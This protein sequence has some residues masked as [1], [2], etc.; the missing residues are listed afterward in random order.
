MT[1][2]ITRIV[3]RHGRQKRPESDIVIEVGQRLPPFY[4][5]GQPRDARV[6]SIVDGSPMLCTLTT[7]HDIMVPSS[8]VREITRA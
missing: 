5:A 1:D 2:T 3:I 7:G 8:F 6:V 4:Q